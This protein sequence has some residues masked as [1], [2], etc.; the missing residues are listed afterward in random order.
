MYITNAGYGK[1]LSIKYRL[2]QEQPHT[3]SYHNMQLLL[4]LADVIMLKIDD[5]VRDAEA[6]IDAID[7]DDRPNV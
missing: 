2:Q 3:E 6:D 7:V 4:P 5:D 1:K